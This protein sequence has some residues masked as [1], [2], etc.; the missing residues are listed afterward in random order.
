MWSGGHGGCDVMCS[1]MR[2]RVRIW[3]LGAGARGDQRRAA[4]S[5]ASLG[6]TVKQKQKVFGIRLRNPR[7]SH[8]TLVLVLSLLTPLSPLPPTHSG[9]Y[10]SLPAHPPQPLLQFTS[11]AQAQTPPLRQ[12]RVECINDRQQIATRLPRGW[13]LWF[14]QRQPTPYRL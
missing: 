7:S 6:H 3:M 10:S 9:V 2:A 14:R 12:P 8:A 5:L 4:K 11:Q 1:V 13:R